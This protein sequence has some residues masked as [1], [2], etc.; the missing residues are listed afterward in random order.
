M[1][2]LQILRYNM[3]VMSLLWFQSKHCAKDGKLTKPYELFT[4]KKT[5]L[6]KFQILFCPCVMKKY[7]ATTVLANGQKITEDI[8]KA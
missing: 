8:S 1:K 4:E 7:T 3:L 5:S 6:S 2:V